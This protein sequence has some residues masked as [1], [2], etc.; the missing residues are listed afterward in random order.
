MPLIYDGMVSDQTSRFSKLWR[1]FSSAP[2][3]QITQ[4]AFDSSPKHLS[5]LGRLR[6]ADRAEAGDLW[7][8]TQDLLYSREIQGTLLQY[9]L[10]F[11]LKAWCADLRGADSSYGGFVEYFY[12][13]LANK[14]VFDGHLTP[15]QTMA[16]SEFMRGSILEEIDD[17]RGPGYRGASVRPYRWIGALTTHGVLLPD[18]DQ[19]WSNWWSIDTVGRAVAAVQYISCLMYGANENP[20]FARWTPERGG[21]PPCLWEFEGHLYEHSWLEPNTRFLRRILNLEEVSNVLGLA[22]ERLAGQPEHTLATE[23]K[24]D[25]PLCDKTLAERCAELPGLLETRQGPAKLI[26]WTQ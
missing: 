25:I 6:P 14:H 19:L 22:V 1:A 23:V 21:G 3:K 8:Y 15:T 13:V 17:Q 2:P 9:L 10:P 12:P 5:R 26:E 16:V 20:V 4:E 18:V 7:E 11:C 24:N